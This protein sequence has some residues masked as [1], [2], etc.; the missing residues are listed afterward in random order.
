MAGEHAETVAPVTA[1]DLRSQILASIP[2]EDEAPAKVEA[3]EEEAAEV[4][5]DEPDEDAEPAVEAAA[6]TDEDDD[7][8]EETSDDDEPHS[9]PETQKRLDTVRRAEKRSRESIARER[10][11]FE[12]ERKQHEADLGKLREFQGLAKRIK[13]DP[14]AALRLLGASED[15]FEIIAQALYSE[16]KAGAADP[17]RK[18]AAAR[19]LREREKEDKLTAQEKRLAELEAKIE[20]QKLESEAQAESARYI[21]EVNSAAA[22]KYPLV[23]HL[24][25]SDPDESGQGI[26]RA[27]EMLL[28]KNNGSTPKASAVVAEYDRAERARLKRIGIDPDTIAKAKT[29]AKKTGDAKPVN[30]TKTTTAPKGTLTKAEIL[31]QLEAD[32][33]A[34]LH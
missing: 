21:D 10:Q 24:L 30:G 6:D 13:Y 31:A 23:A 7:S 29:A 15:D 20:R 3:V 26:V 33:E 16:S 32:G 12:S 25:K 22:A 1:A 18:E 14:A 4:E 28:K 34:D 27:Y 9:D 5:A 8:D 17:K 19:L 2:D 11:E